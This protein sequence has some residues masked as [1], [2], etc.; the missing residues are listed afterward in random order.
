MTKLSRRVF[1]S[2]GLVISLAC[3]DGNFGSS[4]DGNL[5]GSDAEESISVAECVQSGFADC[6]EKFGLANCQQWAGISHVSVAE[7]EINLDDVCEDTGDSEIVW[8]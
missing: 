4:Y 5:G 6:V 8:D 2:I 7:F 1:F 3:S